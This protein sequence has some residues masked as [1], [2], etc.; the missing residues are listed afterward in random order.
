MSSKNLRALSFVAVTLLIAVFCSNA[1]A[2]TWRLGENEKWQNVTDAPLSKYMLAVAGVKQLIEKGKTDEAQLALAQLKK[3]FTEMTGPD[4]DLL[5]EAEILYSKNKWSKA[6]RKYDELI[7]AYPDS[8]L[9]DSAI[10]RQFQ[11]AT[12]FLNGEKRVALKFLKLSAYEEGTK[13]MRNIA[14]R[15][16]DAPI[17][18]RALLAVA[19][20]Y[21][22]RELYMDAYEAWTDISVRWPTDELGRD[23]LLN[24]AQMLHSAYKGYNY[25]SAVLVSAKSYYI[26]FKLRYPELAAKYDIDGKVALIDQQIAYKQYKT[27]TYYDR[28]DE[29]LAADLYYQMTVDQWP[30]S[31]GAKLANVKLEN[32]T[33]QLPAPE[34]NVPR[35][36]FD[37]MEMFLDSWFGFAKLKK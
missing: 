3:D 25:D 36:A 2:D 9:Y 18:K 37:G 24:M 21:E 12:A 4:L 34:K 5:I 13:I 26:N 22:K 7:K 35:K 20:S 23:A 6:V 16:G 14:D 8:G 32:I 1:V 17:A 15:T 19:R 29:E 33:S 10:E 11:I 28:A 30:E 27:G 31:N